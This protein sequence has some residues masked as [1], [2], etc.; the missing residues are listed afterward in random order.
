MDYEK[1]YKALKE[2]L[3]YE[4][5]EE[6]NRQNREREF[7]ERERRLKKQEAQESQFWAIDWDDAFRKAIPRYRREADEERFFNEKGEF[8]LDEFFKNELEQVEYAQGIYREEM[9]SAEK[10][11]RLI[12]ERALRKAAKLVEEKYPDAAIAEYL[13][14]DDFDALVNW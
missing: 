14:N 13:R 11:I 5:W 8:P 9:K 6:E 1:E 7:R 3:N 2:Q 4:H 10:L 12:R